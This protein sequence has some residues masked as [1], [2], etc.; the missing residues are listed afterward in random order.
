MLLRASDMLSQATLNTCS[1]TVS[2]NWGDN[3]SCNNTFREFTEPARAELRYE[4]GQPLG[5]M[6]IRKSRQ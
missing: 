3:E 2:H 1:L 5:P 4:Q 6:V